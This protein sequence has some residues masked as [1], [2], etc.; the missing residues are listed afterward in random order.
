[1][2]IFGIGF[3]NVCY[4]SLVMNNDAKYSWLVPLF[5]IVPFI[6]LMMIFKKDYSS[7]QELKNKFIFKFLIFI[8]A[9]L[10]SA[11]LIYYSSVILTSW[12]YEESSIFWFIIG[13]GFLVITL[14][15]FKTTSIIRVGFVWAICYL[16]IAL[17]G[18]SIHNESDIMFLFPIE[19][20][21][22]TFINNI[23]FLIVPLDNL[24]YFFIENPENNYPK[25]KTI[26]ISGIISLTLCIIQLIINLSLVNYRFYAGLETPA[27]EAFFMY[28]SR[29]HIG[30]YDIVLIINV[31]MTLLYKGTLYGNL[32]L[33]VFPKNK[34]IYFI[35]L[36]ALLLIPIIINM[37]YFKYLKLLI[38]YVILGII[39]A[40]YL[41]LIYY[42]RSKKN[43]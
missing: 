23:F 29:N 30:H 10:S 40:I 5:L 17:F 3:A 16:L 26:I 21:T 31:L 42:Q 15:L 39:L 33:Q 24:I 18:L 6:L 7:Y 1:M 34:R 11:I 12:F 43:E 36:V 13:C 2:I 14:G 38:S 22:S 9:I 4:L 19:L 37:L 35:P 28:Y 41:A 27:I 25:R 20:K 8:Y 32:T